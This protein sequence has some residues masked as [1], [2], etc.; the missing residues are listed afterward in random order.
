MIRPRLKLL[1]VLL[2]EEDYGDNDLLKAIAKDAFVV[3]QAS[4]ASPLTERAALVLPG[5]IWSEQNSTLT[6]IE[7]RIQKITQAVEP[8]GAEQAG[9]GGAAVVIDSTRQ[10]DRRFRRYSLD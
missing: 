4:Y 6:N 2:G 5:A 8:V 10:E 1:Y 3:V 7:G 9:L